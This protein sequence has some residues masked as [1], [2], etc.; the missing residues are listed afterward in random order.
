[1]LDRFQIFDYDVVLMA[2]LRGE[3]FPEDIFND[4]RKRGWNE[5]RIELFKKLV[6]M[7]PSAPDL[8]R[9]AVKEVFTPEIVQKYGQMQDFPADFAKWGAQIGLSE[10]W[11]KNYWA[12]HWDLPSPTQGYE[13][14]HRGVIT[15][16][17]LKVLLRALDVMPY[18]RDKLIQIAYA[19]YTRVDIRRMYKLG[20]L[21]REGVK[22]AYKDIGYDDEHA[23]GLTK[24]TE[25]YYAKP[26]QD[27][28]DMEDEE[29]QK[30]RD[31]TR[32]D[33]CDG[34]KR[35]MLT[36]TE[37]TEDLSTLG[38]D[39]DEIDFYL[40]REDLK[41]TQELKD[42]YASNYRQLYVTGILNDDDV[43]SALTT[44]GLPSAEVD[45]LLKLWYIERIRRAERPTRT[46]LARFLRKEIITADEWRTEMAKLGYSDDYIEWFLQD[47]IS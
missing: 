44:L 39:P 21:D 14:L 8:I 36:R 22:K 18:W 25:E 11:C 41:S 32:A 9:M 19:P 24:F 10:V 23:E 29:I 40:D 35:A 13:M 45:N 30:V 46:D 37:A 27:E 38:Y 20:I 16:D 3:K 17:D 28:E 34:Y 1:M 2:W 42:A 4:L 7:I 31:L 47:I 6:Y 15:Y 43:K 26:S 5:A 33:I 12:A